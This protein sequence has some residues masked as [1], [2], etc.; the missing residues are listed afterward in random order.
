L[1]DDEALHKF[2]ADPTNGA[3]EYGITKAERAVL[4]RVLAHLSNK[5]KN[6]YSV[7]RQNS[8]YR[9]SLRLLQNVLHNHGSKQVT[10]ASSDSGNTITVYV[11]GDPSNPGAPYDDPDK[12]YADY[13]YFT[14]EVGATTIGEAMAANVPSNPSVN[15]LWP[16][17]PSSGEA[18]FAATDQDGNSGTLSYQA[19]ALTS[20]STGTVEWFMYSFTL[21]GFASSINGTYQLSY[22]ATTERDPFWFYS[23][24]GEAIDVAGNTSDYGAAGTSFVDFGIEDNTPI[25]WQAIAPD[26]DTG[27]N[28]CY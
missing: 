28:P 15:D 14:G 10:S 21:D 4:R 2:L 23:I 1:K 20:A 22:E 6:G 26:V 3:E 19:I 27:F 16:T 24:N 7:A 18:T 9:R 13:V 11:T 25:F 12:S 17:D 8:S 5:S